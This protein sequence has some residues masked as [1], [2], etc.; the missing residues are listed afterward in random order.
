M[1]L[2]SRSDRTIRYSLFAIGVRRQL[3][4]HCSLDSAG[5]GRP[6]L[7]SWQ[8]AVGTRCAAPGLIRLP[9]I[10]RASLPRHCADHE[11]HRPGETPLILRDNLLWGILSLKKPSGPEKGSPRIPNYH[12]TYLLFLAGF[13]DPG[14]RWIFKFASAHT[15]SLVYC[16]LLFY[17]QST[18][19][20]LTINGP[21]MRRKIQVN[22][23]SNL[24]IVTL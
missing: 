8:L 6:Q 19:L 14:E 1:C 23:K 16:A 9:A 2:N 21:R 17:F 3:R 10:T 20:V 11:C 5:S 7:A 24:L 13:P 15:S 4:H 12:N 18:L 22:F